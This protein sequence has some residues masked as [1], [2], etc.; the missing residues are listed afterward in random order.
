MCPGFD[1]YVSSGDRRLRVDVFVVLNSAPLPTASP[2]G[3]PCTVGIDRALVVVVGWSVAVLVM[4]SGE[5][6]ILCMHQHQK[7]FERKILRK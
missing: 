5:V 7:N 6:D 4:C 1:G 2:F 3:R